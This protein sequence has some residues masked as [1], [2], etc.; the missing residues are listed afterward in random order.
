MVDGSYKLKNYP[1]A[2]PTFWRTLHYVLKRFFLQN[3][4]LPGGAP[5]FWRNMLLG[6]WHNGL[7][8]CNLA[9]VLRRMWLANA[10]KASYILKNLFFLSLHFEDCSCPH[11]SEGFSN[12]SAKIINAD[13]RGRL[14]A[15][16]S[17][18]CALLPKISTPAGEY[19]R[20]KPCI[21]NRIDCRRSLI[22]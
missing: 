12:S 21:S 13:G 6:A 2:V 9:A 17:G 22:R 20:Q 19:F 11:Q 18:G 4:E 7:W 5:T 14:W 8:R 16:R 10:W 15:A 3:E 1:A